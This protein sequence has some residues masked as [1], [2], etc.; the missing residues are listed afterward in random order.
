MKIDIQSHI[1]P[2]EFINHM[3][4]NEGQLRVSG[5]DAYGRMAI[6]DS[7][8][9]TMLTYFVPDSPFVDPEKHIEDMKRYDIDMQVLSVN[10]PGVDRIED[11]YEAYS[12]CKVIND[13]LSDLVQKY[14]GYFAALATIPFNSPELAVQEMKRASEELGLHGFVMPSNTLGHFYDSADYDIILQEAEAKG[15]PFFIH[16]SQPVVWKEL[17]EDYN[18]P[19][20]YGWPFD[21]TL[22]LA[23][24]IFSGKLRKFPNLNIIAAHGG[25]MVPFFVGRV[26]MLLKDMRGSGKPPASGSEHDIRKVYYDSAVFNTES[27]RLLIRNIGRDKVIYGTDYPFGPERGRMCYERSIS[28]IRALEDKELEDLIFCKNLMNIMKLGL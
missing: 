16:P 7:S 21:T 2:R 22:C 8:T 14:N 5:P 1:F 13:A 27:I 17:G 19:L 28:T 11:P 15:M 12:L 4:H 25:G 24:L 6:M 9:K 23:H 10:P 26:D 20:V 3:M 18:I